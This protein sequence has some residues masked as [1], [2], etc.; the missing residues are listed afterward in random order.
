MLINSF[1][2]QHSPTF[3]NRS[4]SFCKKDRAQ[5]VKRHFLPDKVNLVGWH[6]FASTMQSTLR[7]HTN[8]ALIVIVD[9][10]CMAVPVPV[11]QG[12]QPGWTFLWNLHR[13]DGCSFE[14]PEEVL[15]KKEQLLWRRN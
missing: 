11:R 3:K 6:F 1:F 7:C 9:N 10:T 2:M 15:S 12:T 5:P 4:S 14:P 8:P 13:N